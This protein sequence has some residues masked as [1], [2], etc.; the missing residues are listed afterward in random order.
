MDIKK[1][2]NKIKLDEPNVKAEADCMHDC[3]G[4]RYSAKT[5]KNGC[6]RVKVVSPQVTTLL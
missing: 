5:A 3:V 6:R 4:Y 1:I 2:V